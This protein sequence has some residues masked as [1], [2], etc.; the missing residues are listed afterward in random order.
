MKG[1]KGQAISLAQRTRVYSGS[2][3]TKPTAV[4][5]KDSPDWNRAGEVKGDSNSTCSR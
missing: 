4:L 5:E 1:S 2:L 3:Q